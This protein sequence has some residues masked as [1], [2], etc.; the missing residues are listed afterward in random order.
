MSSSLKL[1]GFWKCGLGGSWSPPFREKMSGKL[2]DASVNGK[3][4]QLIEALINIPELAISVDGFYEI[5]SRSV[6]NFMDGASV[7][8]AIHSFRL[9]VK[10]ESADNLEKIFRHPSALHSKSLILARRCFAFV[11]TGQ[12]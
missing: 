3:G 5:K 10:K 7:S 4:D 6:F 11:L 8:F 1:D 9:K 12:I 2:L